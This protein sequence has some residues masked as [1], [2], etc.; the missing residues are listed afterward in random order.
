MI[1]FLKEFTGQFIN[2]DLYPPEQLIF[3]ALG[4]FFW[5]LTYKEVIQGIRKYKIVEIP[6]VVVA[7]DIAWE[8]NW[9][10]ILENDLGK[11]FAWGC[12]IW[13][14]LDISFILSRS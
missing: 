6:M 2:E 10:F 5:I 9:A 8:F 14:F 13:F 7:L 12:A 3:L 11:A 1:E 4:F